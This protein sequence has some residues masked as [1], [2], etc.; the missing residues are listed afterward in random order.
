M[1]GGQAP[2]LLS[3][4]ALGEDN[5]HQQSLYCG[6]NVQ[7]N[8]ILVPNID[9]QHLHLIHLHAQSTHHHPCL[10][11]D[12]IPHHRGVGVNHEGDARAVRVRQRLDLCRHHELFH[13]HQLLE[14]VDKDHMVV[15]QL[16]T[17]G[18]EGKIQLKA[19]QYEANFVKPLHV[20]H[21]VGG[22]KARA[23]EAGLGGEHHGLLSSLLQHDSHRV[24]GAQADAPELLLDGGHQVKCFSSSAVYRHGEDEFN[25]IGQVD[26][27]TRN[28]SIC[29]VALVAG[30][31]EVLLDTGAVETAL[32][33]ALCRFEESI[34]LKY[35]KL[36]SLTNYSKDETSFQVGFNNNN[37]INV[38]LGFPV[39]S[40]PIITYDDKYNFSTGHRGQASG[41][42]GCLPFPVKVLSSKRAYCTVTKLCQVVFTHVGI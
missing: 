12:H 23:D 28:V 20:H 31:T 7:K 18:G 9:N 42:L 3:V 24:D 6:Q 40:V 32:L 19:V 30:G 15:Q 11:P 29:H 41:Y 2:Q 34:L 14:F 35:L 25:T 17:A 22:D 26:L 1:H 16:W 38:M 37:K 33:S 13:G 8:T 4:L 21:Q 36:K 5:L 10:Y 39:F 27:L